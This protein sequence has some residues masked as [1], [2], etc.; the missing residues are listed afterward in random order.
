MERA[1]ALRK[2]ELVMGRS[3]G[4]A[5]F[6]VHGNTVAGNT[7]RLR[8]GTEA[9]RLPNLELIVRGTAADTNSAR[10]SWRSGPP[11]GAPLVA[12][13]QGRIDL[14]DQA[15]GALGLEVAAGGL[16]VGLAEA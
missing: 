3:L 14:Q 8:V 5:R 10:P 12:H 9:D 13:R 6:E 4:P 7:Q 16:G 2:S 15:V 11:E 1:I